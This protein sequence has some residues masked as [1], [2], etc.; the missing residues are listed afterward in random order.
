MFGSNLPGCSL[1]FMEA[2][3]G[4]IGITTTWLSTCNKWSDIG[5]QLQVSTKRIKKKGSRSNE[6]FSQTTNTSKI[7][8]SIKVK[9]L[10]FSRTPNNKN[11]ENHF[12]RATS[13][14]LSCHLVIQT[15][16]FC[17]TKVQCRVPAAC[18]M[19]Y[20]VFVTVVTVFCLVVQMK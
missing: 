6:D 20:E 10:V 2:N 16:P 17:R 5:F 11:D 7:Q 15:R 18:D 19:K 12:Y 13:L 4:T 3:I 1:I 14:K 9:Q 8:K